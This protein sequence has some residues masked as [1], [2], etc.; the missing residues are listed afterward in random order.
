MPIEKEKI[1]IKVDTVKE[2]RKMA[3]ET[4]GPPPSTKAFKDKS[5]YKRKSKHNKKFD[6]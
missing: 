4:I 3:R 6:E 5:K 2:G 1:T